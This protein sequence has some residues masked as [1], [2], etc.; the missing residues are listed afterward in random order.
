MPPSLVSVY[1]SIYINAY[2]KKV[3]FYGGGDDERWLV[4]KKNILR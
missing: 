3:T 2:V 4:E 1:I